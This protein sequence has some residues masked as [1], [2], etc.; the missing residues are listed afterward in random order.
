MNK[1]ELIKN[2]EQAKALSLKE[3]IAYE[4]GK[5]VIGRLCRNHRW[6]DSSHASGRRYD[7]HALRDTPCLKITFQIQDALD[8]SLP[9]KAII[10]GISLHMRCIASC[11][12]C[13]VQVSTL[14]VASSRIRILGRRQKPGQWQAAVPAD[15]FSHHPFSS[16]PYGFPWCLCLL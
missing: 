13:S 6:R 1:I 10:H 11:M 12:A 14:D 5:V 7:H 8:G 9:R 4:D 2:I 16:G 3:Q 15:I